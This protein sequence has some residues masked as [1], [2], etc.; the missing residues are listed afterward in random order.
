MQKLSENLP[1]TAGVYFFYKNSKVIYIGKAI[2][3]KRR[4]SSYFDL[5]LE[6]K[7]ARM[8]K[9]AT[10]LSFIKVD[11]ELEA[12]LLEAKLIR[13]YMPHYNVIS[14][15]DKHPLYI[16]ITKDKFPRIITTRKDGT[17]GPFPSSRTVYAVLRMLRKIFPFSDHKIGRRPCLY[18][19]IGLCNPCPNEISNNQDP[20]IKQYQIKKYK[21][22]IK[23]LK[24]ILDGKIDKVTKELEKEMNSFSKIENFENAALVRNQLTNLKYITRPQMP[25]EFYIQNPNLYEDQRKLEIKEL[26][27]LIKNYKLKINNLVRIECFDIAHLAGTYATASMIT[28]VGGEA[29]K[30]YYRHFKIKKAKRGDDYDSMR[31]V[32]KRRALHFNDWGIPDLIIVDGGVGQVSAFKDKIG[33]ILVVGIVKNPDKLIVNDKK[34]KLEGPVLNLVSRMRD[35]AHRFARRYHHKLISKEITNYSK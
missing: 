20:I 12:L 18:S 2:N 31:E 28:F 35:E 10:R 22:N 15:D 4:V 7:T 29:D 1:E 17:Y 6:S 5:D 14:K 25:T 32:A 9:E 11:S 33:G 34:I 30:N 26:E 24:L 27:K 23:N 16:T 13:S 8:I 19:H 3:L 21:S